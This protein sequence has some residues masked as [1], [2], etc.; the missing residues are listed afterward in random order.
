MPSPRVEILPR[1]KARVYLNR[2]ENLIAAM[3]AALLA[4]NPDGVAVTAVQAAIAFADAY[5][6]LTV[7]QR[8]RSPDHREVVSLISSARTRDSGQIAGLVQRMLDRKSEVEYGNRAVR[9]DDAKDLANSARKLA[10]L[11]V[12]CFD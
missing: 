10:R 3:E 11:V 12:G 9:I 2:A 7:Q 1:Q 6:V 8:S 5:T 4:R